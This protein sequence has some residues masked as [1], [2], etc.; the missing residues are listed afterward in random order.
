M[1]VF[2]DKKG[3]KA[4]SKELFEKYKVEMGKLEDKLEKNEKQ[5]EIF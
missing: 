2:Y 4:K 1:S 5:K 3:N